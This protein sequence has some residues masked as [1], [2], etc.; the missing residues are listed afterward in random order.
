MYFKMTRTLPRFAFLLFTILC[1]GLITG[2]VQATTIVQF[3]LNNQM[4]GV[5]GALNNYQVQ[6]YDSQ[7]P[8]TVNN[9]LRY[10]N[11]QNYNNTIIHRSVQGFIVQGGG[12]SPQ[13][14]ATTHQ[15]QTIN[16]IVSY[17]AIVN[18]FSATRSNVRGTIAM[19]KIGG[20]PNSATNQWFINLADNSSNLDNQNGGFTVFGQVVGEGMSLV[21]A[22]SN[23][24]V[25]NLTSYNFNSALTDV[26]FYSPYLYSDYL[27]TF[28]SV[29]VVPTV[30]WK[31]GNSS[32]ATNWSLGGNWSTGTAGPSGAGVNLIFGSQVS[33]N[34]VADMVSSG[35]TV[36]NIYFS[37]STSTT[38]Q[39]SG[40][41]NLTLDNG[42]QASTV[43][44]LGNHTIS[45][46]VVM[47]SNVLF[48][49][50]G[51]LTLSGGINGA[52]DIAT[53]D[54]NIILGGSSTVKSFLANTLTVG[55]GARLTIQPISSGGPLSGAISVVPE[56][57]TAVLL[58]LG[59]F[60][61]LVYRCVLWV[62]SEK[63]HLSA[64]KAQKRPIH[65]QSCW[66]TLSQE[67]RGGLPK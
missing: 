10:V 27:V 38:I 58:G 41:Y 67:G 50:D 12:F 15:I 44:V 61:L 39:S 16:P 35:K 40:H 65:A 59:A 29:A 21:N 52:H 25:Y 33:M 42:G 11:N 24:P 48:T 18:E 45:A 57:S 36:G 23:I 56:P 53:I 63:P 49:D 55:R 47:N 4:A 34:N 20:D 31:G 7:A 60:S 54:A 13:S 43:S 32:G 26:P 62:V 1:V 19:A 17:G 51:T 6:L 14:D 64:R 2:V 5:F 8:I 22:I 46:S 28:P 66:L 37:P 9:F 30:E 3:T